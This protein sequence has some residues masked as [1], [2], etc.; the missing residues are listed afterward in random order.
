MDAMPLHL[1]GD[2]ATTL[3]QRVHTLLLAQGNLLMGQ[4]TDASGRAWEGWNVVAQQPSSQ[5]LTLEAHAA[6]VRGLFAL[7]LATGNV[8][9]R[10]RA[11]AVFDRLEATFYDADARLYATGPAPMDDVTYTPVTFGLLQAAHR[12][13]YELVAARPGNEELALKLETRIGR[14]NKLVLNGW[15]DRNR[16]RLVQWPDECIRIDEERRPLGGMQMAE[17]TLSGE[18]G[19]FGEA[20]VPFNRVK[21]FDRENDC[22]PE[23]DDVQLPASLASAITLHLE[24]KR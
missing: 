13:L 3:S 8:A 24:R 20:V 22:V 9:Y 2:E 19:S 4:L 1:A 23:I 10:A 5:A 12:E 16:D 17:R 11:I 18:I 21:T 14:L 7:Y 15:D 6:A